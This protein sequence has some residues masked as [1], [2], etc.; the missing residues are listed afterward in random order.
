MRLCTTSGVLPPL[1]N[2]QQVAAEPSRTNQSVQVRQVNVEGDIDLNL[3]VVGN[4]Y[5]IRA[6]LGQL[7]YYIG[8]V[9]QL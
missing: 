1:L 8:I 2:S 7:L 4:I 5:I 6:R 9:K 3:V